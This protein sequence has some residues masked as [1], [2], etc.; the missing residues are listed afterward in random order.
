[1]LGKSPP[2][3]RQEYDSM[4][5]EDVPTTAYWGASTQRAKRLFSIGTLFMPME[6]IHHF[7]LQKRIAALANKEL[8]VLDARLADKVIQAAQEVEK[9][10]LDAHFPLSVW[11]TGSGTATH[12]NVNEVI[13]NRANELLGYPLGT[14]SPVHPNDHVNKGQSSNDTFPTVMHLVTLFMLQNKLFPQLNTFIQGL[15]GKAKAFQGMV[16]VGR[17]HLQDAAP[18][19]VSD[20]FHT[21]SLQLKGAKERLEGAMTRL[22]KLAQG[23][24]AVGT[25]LNA[26]PQFAATFAKLLSQERQLPFE[27]HPHP[28]VLFASHDDLAA[29]MSELTLLAAALFKMA[30]DVRFLASGPLC[31]VGEW[32]L[33][34]NEPG[35]SIMPG[36][37]N[38]TQVEALQMICL[39]V[40]GLGSAVV[41]ASF[42]G[43]CQLN[44]MK[45]LMI[46][47]L[48]TSIVLLADAM[49]CFREHALEGLQVDLEVT[50]SYIERSLML[51]T[52]LVPLIGYD[53]ASEVSLYAREKKCTLRQAVLALGVLDEKTFDEK[54]KPDTLAQ[55]ARKAAHSKDEGIS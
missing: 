26:H 10:Q 29:V 53:R 28:F 38:P 31:G 7:G 43:Q 14:K 52:A 44:V 6:V 3:Y 9:G 16:K 4:G 45:P 24:T 15:D 33:P 20:E 11:Q 47:N 25:G 36:K 32:V 1:M 46:S 37:V 55:G 30:T 18:L 8:G 5:T 13:A 49:R 2:L 41:A 54:V 22:F 34:A 51:A 23:G 27:P 21:F 17:T 40:K 19:Y 12:M 42:E 50:R 48:V 35:S 39:Q